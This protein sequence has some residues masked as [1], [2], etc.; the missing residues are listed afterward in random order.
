MMEDLQQN[1]K[2]IQKRE[3]RKKRDRE[4]QRRNRKQALEMEEK[5]Q[6]EI[7]GKSNIM[8]LHL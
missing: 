8:Y 2:A 7:Q 1:Y 6:K 3:K 5:M 4:R